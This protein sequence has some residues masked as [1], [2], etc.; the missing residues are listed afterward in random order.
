MRVLI[1]DDHP[2]FRRFASRLLFEA[3]FAVVGEAADAEGALREAER[4]RPDVV[5]LDVVLPDRSGLAV[6]RELAGSR[7]APRVVLISS[8]SRSDFGDSFEWPLG[9]SFL[10]KHELTAARLRDAL[11]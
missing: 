2:I 4:L 8:R 1:V 11:Q 5:L 10:P 7:A 6:A 9:C 3:G